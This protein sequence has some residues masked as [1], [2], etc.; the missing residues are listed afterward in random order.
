MLEKANIEYPKVSCSILGYERI[1]RLCGIINLKLLIADSCGSSA[2]RSARRS[3]SV[4]SCRLLDAEMEIS[5]I[6]PKTDDKKGGG[7]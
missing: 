4:G 2:L 6:L 7:V 5:E 1:P 3:A